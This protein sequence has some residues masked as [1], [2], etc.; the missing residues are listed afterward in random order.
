MILAAAKVG[1]IWA[2]N[3]YPYDFIERNLRMEL[4]IIAEA[5]RNGV[6]RLVFLGSS[7]IYPK[8]AEQPIRE[9]ALL[10]GPLE[11]TNRPYALAKIAGIELCWS[12]NRQFGRKYFA[13]MPTNLYGLEDKFDLKTSHVLPA[14]LRKFHEAKKRGDKSV[15]IW[16]SGKPMREFLFNDDL[17]EGILFLL[18]TEESK[19]APIFSE[20]RP[21]LINL[22]FGS[23]LSIAELARLIQETVGFKGELRFD[24]S[25]PDGTPRKLMDSNLAFSMGWRPKMSLEEGIR[26]VYAS[27]AQEPSRSGYLIRRA[28]DFARRTI[29]LMTFR[30]TTSKS[31]CHF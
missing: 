1:G 31:S 28:N 13:V 19:L 7:C 21:P 26:R 14:L 17:A 10:T 16:G 8:F 9:E 18:T 2:N 29:R 4:N 23:D 25:K 12:L 3:T 11:P 22:G 30:F 5:H 6:E 24:P 20:E 27:L 15:E